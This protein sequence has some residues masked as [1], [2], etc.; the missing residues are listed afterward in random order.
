[1]NKKIKAI[2][3]SYSF[4]LFFLI[5][6]VTIVFSSSC[7]VSD[8]F[9]EKNFNMRFSI[10]RAMSEKD[11]NLKI[12]THKESVNW[13][14][15]YVYIRLVKANFFDNSQG[16]NPS[17]EINGFNTLTDASDKVIDPLN[18]GVATNILDVPILKESIAI[19]GTG[20]ASQTIAY[21]DFYGIEEGTYDVFAFVD[22]ETRLDVD[23]TT[24]ICTCTRSTGCNA[25]DYTLYEKEKESG[26]CTS[27]NQATGQP[28]PSNGDLFYV[29]D[30]IVVSSS[31]KDRLMELS[32][33]QD[34]DTPLAY[35]GTETGDGDAW[36]EWKCIYHYSSLAG[37]NL[38]NYTFPSNQGYGDNQY[39]LPGTTDCGQGTEDGTN[40]SY[41]QCG[42]LM[43]Y[44]LDYN[45]K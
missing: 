30:N 27:L 39:C 35:A 20:K 41:K 33:R 29:I 18:T 37:F 40:S 31:T 3:T 16:V 43:D 14:S 9:Y 6:L 28:M 23:S 5:I 10:K 45:T 17:N 13:V 2:I 8:V 44:G 7:S 15:K 19:L 22:T 11:N 32:L 21:V 34:T 1:M 38:H 36:D 24:K 26:G 12:Y 25:N 42:T 4:S